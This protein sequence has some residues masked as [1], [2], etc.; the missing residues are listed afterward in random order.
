MKEE[1][2][3]K[4]TFRTHEGH[5]EL[6]VMPFGLTNVP[7]TFQLLMNQVFRPFFLTFFFE[8]FCIIRFFYDILVYSSDLDTH[9]RYL[10]MIFT[11]SSDY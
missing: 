5:Y 11:V 9:E 6:V 1:D 2:I 8:A 7:A 10:S 3:A 4:M